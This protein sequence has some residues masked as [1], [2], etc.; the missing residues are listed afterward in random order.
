M[1][2]L[3]VVIGGLVVLV[4]LIALVWWVVMRSLRDDGIPVR[5]SLEEDG[6]I[7]KWSAEQDREQGEPLAIGNGRLGRARDR[8]VA[9][10]WDPE[11]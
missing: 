10:T 3:R 5:A 1:H 2:T 6:A 9:Q 11:L 8:N 4:V 7:R